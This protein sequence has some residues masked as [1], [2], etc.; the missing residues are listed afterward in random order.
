MAD[1]RPSVV[2]DQSHAPAQVAFCGPAV[3]EV[4]VDP[5]YA[6]LAVRRDRRSN[7]RSALSDIALCTAEVAIVHSRG[8]V[9]VGSFR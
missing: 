1:S 8:R 5:A 4:H 9:F 3:I 6:R 7:V 2:F